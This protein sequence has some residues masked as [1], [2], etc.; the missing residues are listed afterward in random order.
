[1][2]ADFWEKTEAP[3]TWIPQAASPKFIVRKVRKLFFKFFLWLLFI[4]AKTVAGNALHMPGTEL[5]SLYVLSCVLGGEAAL[6][7]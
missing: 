1:L 5:L 7:S 6:S 2:P 4:F 3:V